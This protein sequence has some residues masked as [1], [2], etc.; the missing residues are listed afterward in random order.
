MFNIIKQTW[1]FTSHQSEWL[2]L[3]TQETAGAGKDVEKEEH[4]S[5]AGGIADGATTLEISL[6]VPQET[7]HD[8]SWEPCYTTPGHIPG[9]FFH[10][11]QGHKNGSIR[12]L[13]H[14]D[15]QLNQLLV[16]LQ[17]STTTLEISLAVPQKTGLDTSS[18]PCYTSPGHINKG[19]QQAIK[20]HAPLCS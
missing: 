16:G 12:I 8:T 6:A 7:G 2:R 5:T 9:G 14:A 13:L 15:L 18:G 1:D 19:F 3:K 10:M 20:T 17:D 4:S 11:Q